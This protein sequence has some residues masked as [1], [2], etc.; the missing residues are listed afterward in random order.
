MRAFAMQPPTI[1]HKIDGYQVDRNANKCMSCHA[2][3]RIEETQAMP[4]SITHY[5]DRDGND[6]RRRVAAALLLHAM[7]RGAGRD[8]SRWSRTASRTSTP[9]ARA[10]RAARPPASKDRREK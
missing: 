8:R 4:I 5:M 7:P 6:P 2:R 9:C 10:R 3:T 1:P